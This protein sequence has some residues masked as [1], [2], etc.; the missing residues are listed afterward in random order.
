MSTQ[1][2]THR[3]VVL[4]LTWL[5]SHAGH[6]TGDYLVQRDCDARHKQNHT[7]EGRKALATHAV[8]YGATQAVVKT[9]VFRAAGVRI[10]WRA[11][12]AGQLV[13]MVLHAVI[14]DGR[15]LRRFAT[16]V[17]KLPFHDLNAGGVNGRLLLDQATHKGLQ[18][19]LGAIITALLARKEN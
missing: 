12:V 10:P 19:P 11:L 14:D 15:L 1:P 7:P 18:I 4:A 8:T 2:A 13:E 6:E 5:A 9:V 17:G 16:A 3:A